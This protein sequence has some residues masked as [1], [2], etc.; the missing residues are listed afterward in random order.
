M[1][2]SRLLAY[3]RQIED[4]L[5]IEVAAAARLLQEAAERSASA[6]S[7]AKDKQQHYAEAAKRG[8]TIEETYRWYGEIEHASAQA[9]R[10]A[11]IQGRLHGEWMKKQAA[12]VDAMQERKKLDIL[13]RRRR[14][15]R[16]QEQLHDEQRLMDEQAARRRRGTIGRPASADRDPHG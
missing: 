7:E 3:R 9:R 8:L 6:E 2:L 14:E 15:A 13:I 16:Q 10:A 12:V 1:N 11:E 4:A 5:R